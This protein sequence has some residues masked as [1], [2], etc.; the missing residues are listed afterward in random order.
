MSVCGR[1]WHSVAIDENHE[2]LINK[3][4]KSSIL[5]QQDRSAYSLQIKNNQKPSKKLFPTKKQKK[6]EI[7][8][9]FSTQSNDLKSVQNIHSQVCALQESGMLLVT[10]NNRGLSNYF[11]GKEANPAQQNDLLNFDL[12]DSKNFYSE[13]HQ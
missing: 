6:N 7:T 11:T 2:M 12:L 8:G 1:S 13:E 3:D 9:P 4:C 5:H 10:K